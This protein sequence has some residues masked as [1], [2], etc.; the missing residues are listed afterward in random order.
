MANMS[1]P[2]IKCWKIFIESYDENQIVTILNSG[3]SLKRLIEIQFHSNTS[4]LSSRTSYGV[5]IDFKNMTELGGN[6]FQEV[7]TSESHRQ[8]VKLY[9][10]GRY[11]K[12]LE[13]WFKEFFPN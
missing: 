4:K 8:V 9:P 13:G 3:S 11:R 10:N 5:F 6:S 1:T 7:T 12:L 2:E